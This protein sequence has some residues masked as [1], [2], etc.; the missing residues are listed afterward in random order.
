M[1]NKPRRY[2]R[3]LVASTQ[4]GYGMVGAVEEVTDAEVKR[5]SLVH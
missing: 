4:A 1:L 5:M 2:K 3:R